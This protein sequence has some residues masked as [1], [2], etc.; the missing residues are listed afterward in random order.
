M[1]PDLIKEA[2]L[3]VG[4]LL[5]GSG[6]AA[7]VR[8]IGQNKVDAFAAL[9]AEQT[10]MRNDLGA[11]LTELESSNRATETRND[12]LVKSNADMGA[13]LSMAEATV[14]ALT[15]SLA[16]AQAELVTVRAERDTLGLEVAQLRRIVDGL[17]RRAHPG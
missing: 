16:G 17:D 11:R 12:E 5:G 3:L 8:A 1:N 7:L 9:S 14:K 4:G 10:K 13:R 15:E 2:T 6:I